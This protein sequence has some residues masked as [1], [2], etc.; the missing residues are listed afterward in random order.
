MMKQ[1]LPLVSICIP[2]YNRSNYLKKTLAAIISQKPFRE[3][4]VELV[5][6]D[7]ASTDGTKDFMENL[8]KKYPQIRY[9][10]NP[11][12]IRDENFPLVLSMATGKLRCL[13]NDTLIYKR[14]HLQN[15]CNMALRYDREKPVIFFGNG[16]CR[17]RRKEERVYRDMDSAMQ[18][19]SYWLTW[20]GGITVWA[21][22]CADIENDTEHCK[23]FLWQT[24]KMLKLMKKKQVV[25]VNNIPFGK[26]Q[27][28]P[29]KDVSYGIY[30]VFYENL[31]SILTPYVIE[32]SLSQE[33]LGKIKKDILYRFF[34]NNMAAWENTDKKF[35]YG[36]EDLVK[37]IL[38]KYE[39]EDYYH[40]FLR[41]Y[42]VKKIMYPIKQYIKKLVKGE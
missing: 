38:A 10:R 13:C 23:L 42:Q 3:N 32:Q 1:Q 7:N 35:L 31:F 26:V 6:S 8:L 4:K 41:Y 11:Q 12:N 14:N 19:I 22:D 9:H 5:V 15:L 20:L 39:G 17:Y 29:N 18:D 40:S 34:V 33:T 25:V 2:T 37:K 27:T 24:G 36:K 21:D 30:K 16:N 28:I